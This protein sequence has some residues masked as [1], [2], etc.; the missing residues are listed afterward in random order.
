MAGKANADGLCLVCR[1][2]VQVRDGFP[3]LVHKKPTEVRV[4]DHDVLCAGAFDHCFRNVLPVAVLMLLHA[5]EAGDPIQ[6][7]R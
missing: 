4:V 2:S 5:D 6:M 3:K 1:A 7:V